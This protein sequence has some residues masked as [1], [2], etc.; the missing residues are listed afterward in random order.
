MQH[1]I[2]VIIAELGTVHHG[3]SATAPELTFDTHS[4]PSSVSLCL[5]GLRIFGIDG[6][7]QVAPATVVRIAT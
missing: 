5:V 4:S 6:L 2:L 1:Q 3:F 7:T